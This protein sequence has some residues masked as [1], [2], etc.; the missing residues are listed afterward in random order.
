MF[1]F[2]AAVAGGGSSA[3]EIAGLI[4]AAGIPLAEGDAL[5]D[6]DF[7]VVSAA[8]DGLEILQ[9]A[10]AEL[11]EL[12]P[13]HAILAAD[14]ATVSVTEIADATSRPEK[15]VGFHFA[16]PIAGTRAVEVV[17]GEYTSPE[18]VQ[19]A[20]R[21]AQAIRRT[22]IR[23][24]DAPG[25]V[26]GRILIS[27]LSEAWRFQEETG[28]PIEEVDR[29]LRY[30]GVATLGAFAVAE[31]IGADELL[32]L[33][34]HL[35]ETFGERFHVPRELRRLL[36]GAGPTEG[37]IAD[38]TELVERVTLKAIVEACL[39]LEEGV[40]SM[41]DTELAF[42]T[43][44]AVVAAPLAR[45]DQR[46]LEQ[47][48]DTLER[49]EDGWAEVFAPPA[50]LRRLV[51]QGRLG[52]SSGQGFFAY[53]RPD[54]GF[55]DSP[56]KLETR[57]EV[58][59]AWLDRPPANSISPDLAAALR[60]AFEGA[61]ADGKVRAL[62]IASANPMLFCAGAD[63]KGFAQMQSSPARSGE[64]LGEMHALARELETG[65]IVTIAAVGGPALGGGCELAMACDLRIA[66][67]SAS[68]GQP[69]ISLGIIPG[70]GGTQRLPRLVGT[71][72]ALEMNLT[73]ESIAA[74]DAY[75]LGLVNRLVP[76][77]ELLDAALAWARALAAK[78]PLAVRAIK[79]VSAN[80]D[81]GAGIEAE[82]QAFAEVFAS[83]D[84]R[85]GISAFVEKRSPTFRG[86]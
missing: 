2:K 55:E 67:E 16:R 8:E 6:V 75:E 72:K 42:A 36:L 20:S 17:E 18:T 50:I 34:E 41:R 84:A 27:C 29:V 59:I 48:L 78:A 49:A 71:S 7:V 22:P 12:T 69:E 68:F 63:I 38:G 4:A 77:H 5:G 54:H 52:R 51:V 21:F 60:R 30:A 85:E 79:R 46:G 3:G 37:S 15:V 86:E 70:F 25:F 74:E 14:T 61:A 44:A 66:S 56:V 83:A 40:A 64:L 82:Q 26:V 1:V 53:P 45:A 33:A 47:V 10:F 58:A 80:S 28:V 23:C 11:D 19:V 24:A 35:H 43:G 57:G 32:L 62:I 13:G 39:V 73:G 9:D 76:D 81:L 31:A 65:G